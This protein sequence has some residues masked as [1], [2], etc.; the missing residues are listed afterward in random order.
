M[1]TDEHD[2]ALIALCKKQKPT[3]RSDS[4]S[5]QLLAQRRKVARAP[6]MILCPSSFTEDSWPNLTSA[7]ASK[8][9]NHRECRCVWQW[10][11]S[12]VA[13]NSRGRKKRIQVAA[14]DSY[15]HARF[16]LN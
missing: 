8:E 15:G 6:L 7:I 1:C 11:F 13:C 4:E 12:G 9:C 3:V 5:C 10:K 16:E 2:A 14:R